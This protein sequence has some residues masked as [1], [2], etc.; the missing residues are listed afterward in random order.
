M[1]L[2]HHL[3]RYYD[4]MNGSCKLHRTMRT[5][6]QHRLRILITYTIFVQILCISG[7]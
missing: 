3:K 6:L 1:F 2:P 5:I 4:F 7:S